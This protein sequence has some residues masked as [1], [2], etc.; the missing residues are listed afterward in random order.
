MDSDRI[1]LLLGQ[2]IL[3]IQ[4]VSKIRVAV[5]TPLGHSTQGTV[6]SLSKNP[7]MLY[8]QTRPLLATDVLQWTGTLG[9][10]LTD[11]IS[12]TSKIAVTTEGIRMHQKLAS[13]SRITKFLMQG[14]AVGSLH[15]AAGIPGPAF[16]FSFK[17]GCRETT[18][19]CVETLR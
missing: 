14:R 13:S 7:A 10:P 17:I 5:L 16:C 3:S 9:Q 15:Q 8:S 2:H 19:M 6:Q 12:M 4:S 11:A 18:S 1:S